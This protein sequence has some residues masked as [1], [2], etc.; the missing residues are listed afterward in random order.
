MSVFCL[1]L[2]DFS[3]SHI[4]P[5]KRKNVY[6]S[7]R[8]ILNVYQRKQTSFDMTLAIKAHFSQNINP[9]YDVL[10]ASDMHMRKND[11]TLGIPN[12]SYKT[13]PNVKLKRRQP[14]PHF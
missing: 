10:T 11:V 13:E 9:H 7:D 5:F 6:L 8:Y 14:G 2:L 3:Q 4:L 1:T 12:S